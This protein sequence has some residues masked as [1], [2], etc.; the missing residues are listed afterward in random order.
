MLFNFALEYA[1][2][3]VQE[4]EEGLELKGTHQLLVC[5]VDI[6]ISGKYIYTIKKTKSKH[7]E[8]MCLMS[9][10]QMPDKIITY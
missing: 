4:N 3:K 5:A 9:H 7:W 1:I 10:H 2:K 6:N 8:T